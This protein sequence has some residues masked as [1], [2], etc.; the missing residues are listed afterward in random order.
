MKVAIS[1]IGS[2][3]EDKMD[4]RFGRAA[5][6]LIVDSET[7]IFT[8]VDNS[9]A[10]ASAGA[11]IAAAQSVIDQQADAVITGQL[12]PN[13]LD[14]LKSTEILLYQ[15]LSGTAY[16]NIIAFNQQKLQLVSGC[17]PAHAGMG[18]RGDKP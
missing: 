7:L 16:D 4:S 10:A 2:T 1:C 8:V 11:G 5:C 12:G 17:G 15:G 14:V 13:A 3:L 6:F 18:N 9:A